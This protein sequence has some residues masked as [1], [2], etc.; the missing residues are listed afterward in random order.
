MNWMTRFP[1]LVRRALALVFVAMAVQLTGCASMPGSA[2]VRSSTDPLESY[3]RT[4]FEFNRKVDEIAIEPLA[5]TYRDYVPEVI[6][7]SVRNFFNNLRDARTALN[8]LLQGKPDLAGNDLLRF[9]INSTLGF[10]G[11]ADVASEIGLER[12]VE[13]FGQTLGVWG[14]PSGP[15]LVLPLLGPSSFRDGVGFVVDVRTDLLSHL[16]EDSARL[17]AARGVSL[18]DTREGLLDASRLLEGIALDPYLFVRDGYLQRRRN[19]VWDGNPPDR[20]RDD[21][22]SLR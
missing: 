3:N 7:L 22:S 10:A 1:V 20:E 21:G 8:Q 12:N 2:A 19:L 14:F 17:N 9:A 4:M 13:D 15:Y 5:M 6:R 18:V 16:S 11:I